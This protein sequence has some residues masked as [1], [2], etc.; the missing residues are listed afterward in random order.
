MYCPDFSV[1]VAAYLDESTELVSNGSAR[2]G[3]TSTQTHRVDN[4][5]SN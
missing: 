2:Q 4:A 3:S 5:P 1:T